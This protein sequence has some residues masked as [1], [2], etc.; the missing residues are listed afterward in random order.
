MA[1][2]KLGLAKSF[3]LDFLLVFAPEKLLSSREIERLTVGR[4]TASSS[5]YFTYK[6]SVRVM[7]TAIF[8]A[9]QLPAAHD[10]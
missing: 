7:H 2:R 5:Y 9:K 4:K 1:K 8:D 10:R 6:S 3:L